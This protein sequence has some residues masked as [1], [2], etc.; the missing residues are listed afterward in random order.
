MSFSHGPWLALASQTT[1]PVRTS[2]IR[3]GL[4]WPWQSTGQAGAR[5]A[6]PQSPILRLAPAMNQ[7]PH[8]AV[9]HHLKP[10]LKLL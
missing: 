5:V 1:N 6:L 8:P 7:K 2:R 10:K 4:G 3:T 9:S